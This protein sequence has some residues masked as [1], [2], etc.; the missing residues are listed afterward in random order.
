[1]VIDFN[2]KKKKKKRLL[3]CGRA[4]AAGRKN[5]AVMSFPVFFYSLE[6]FSPGSFY[7]CHNPIEMCLEKLPESDDCC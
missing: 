6:S 1:V 7:K 3:L 5:L 2:K 4:V